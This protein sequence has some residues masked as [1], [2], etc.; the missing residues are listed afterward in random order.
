MDDCED[1]EFIMTAQQL[2]T[3]GELKGDTKDFIILCAGCEYG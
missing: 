2:L 3:V 1:E